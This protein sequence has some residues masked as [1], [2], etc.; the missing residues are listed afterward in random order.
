MPRF[1]VDERIREAYI[2]MATQ[3]GYRPQAAGGSSAESDLRNEAASYAK[4]FIDEEQTTN[5]HVGVSDYTTNRA[6]VYT[7]EAAR[8]LCCG[9]LGVDHALK[10]LEMA[11]MEVRMQRGNYPDLPGDLRGAR[12]G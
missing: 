10:L 9:A 8:L 7:I 1:S 5:F 3:A 11:V 4:R 2:E 12:L 6:F